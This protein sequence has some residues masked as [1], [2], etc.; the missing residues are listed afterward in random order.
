MALVTLAL[1]TL[2]TALALGAGS[3]LRGDEIAYLVSGDGLP[4]RIDGLDLNT[5]IKFTL[6]RDVLWTK[7]TWSPD[8]S[9]IAFV[10]RQ[11]A[12]YDLHVSD[13]ERGAIYPVSSYPWPLDGLAWS[14][15]G[16]RIAFYS[17][18]SAADRQI[19]I[20]AVDGRNRRVLTPESNSDFPSWS[21][22]SKQLVYRQSFSLYVIDAD[23]GNRQKIGSNRLV[24]VGPPDWSPDGRRIAF[25]AAITGTSHLRY[26]L[27]VVELTT[28]EVV[29]TDQAVACVTS[30]TWS[31]DSRRI[32]FDYP[33]RAAGPTQWT[34][35]AIWDAADVHRGRIEK[36]PVWRP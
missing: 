5:G 17:L 1:A 7:P 15:D 25:A 31:P 36:Y 2:L 14:P 24:V 28:G 11:E 32:A 26:S 29:A 6:A 35:T 10:S 13:A 27:Y 34:W 21:P 23:G 8:G 4:I 12:N 16:S 3:A 22:D 18:R 9:R 20:I 19:E 30:P 33:R